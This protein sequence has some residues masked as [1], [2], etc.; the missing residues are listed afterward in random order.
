MNYSWQLSGNH[1]RNQPQN[2]AKA[3]GSRTTCV[4]D[5]IIKPRTYL[6]SETPVFKYNN[7]LSLLGL[8]ELVCFATCSQKH[9]E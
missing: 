5:D 3:E 8:F 7:L 9:S 4:L 1:G 6:T 2:E